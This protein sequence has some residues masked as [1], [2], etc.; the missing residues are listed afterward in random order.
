VILNYEAIKYVV[1]DRV[2]SITFNRPERMNAFGRQIR[3][4]LP[5]AIKH[6]D[7]DPDVR[8]LLLSGA[9]GRAFSTGY[10]HK[11]SAQAEKN[12]TV[13]Q[14]RERMDSAFE[15]TAAAM[16]CSKPVIAS[17]EGYC[18]AG[19]LELAQMCD[20][21]YC[22][23]DAKFGAVE[24]RFSHGIATMIMPWI[25]GNHCRELIYTGDTIDAAEALRIGLVTRVFPKEELAAQTMKIAKRMSRVSLSCLQWNKRAINQTFEIMGQ[26]PALRYGVEAAAIMDAQSSP[27]YERYDEIRRT[28][29]LAKAIQWRDSQFKP[30]E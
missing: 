15:F 3:L 20:I 2:A 29:G 7:N 24:A 14:W 5:D 11:E 19:A 6:A 22:S 23:E 12:R 13:E 25:I 18:L 10:D 16:A 9:G 21:R 27:E 26:R 4:E 28:E 8:V 17:I 30:Y 1:D